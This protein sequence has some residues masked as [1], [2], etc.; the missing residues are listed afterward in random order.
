MLT[1]EITSNIHVL[2]IILANHH[3]APTY[4]HIPEVECAHHVH[5]GE[6]DA[7][8]DHQAEVEVAEHHQGHLTHNIVTSESPGQ[9]L[10]HSPA[11]PRP[12]PGPGYARA[13]P[14]WWSQSPR[15]GKSKQEI[16]LI[17]CFVLSQITYG[18][19]CE[20]F[21]RYVG[22]RDNLINL[23]LCWKVFRR[24]RQWGRHAVSGFIL[25]LWFFKV[26]VFFLTVTPFERRWWEEKV[27]YT[28][29]PQQ[30]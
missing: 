7:G 19:R 22:L 29:A 11:P 8:H 25:M 3:H 23:C 20:R 21:W 30:I 26:W 6:H 13:P 10:R 14:Q 4:C 12:G 27:C 1:Q 18:G 24:G 9:G 16:Q 5:E 2:W 28:R 17:L 15:P